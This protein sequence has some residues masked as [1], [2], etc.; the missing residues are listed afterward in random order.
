MLVI[1]VVHSRP[2]LLIAFLPW[3]FASY[4]L[5]LRDE[6]SRLAPDGVLFPK[7]IVPSPIGSYFKFWGPPRTRAISYV[8]L[9][10]SLTPLEYNSKVGYP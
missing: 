10:V 3:Q 1:A 6:A 7:C 8:V 9:G 5:I 4:P 2:G